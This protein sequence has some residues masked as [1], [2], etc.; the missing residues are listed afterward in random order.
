MYAVGLDVDTRAY[1]TAASMIIAV[2]TGIKVFSWLNITRAYSRIVREGSSLFDRFPR[3]NRKYLPENQ[4]C[5]T[6]V[7]FGYH[8]GSSVG[9]PNFTSIMAHI[10]TLPQYVFNVLVGILL[11]DG[12]L[13]HPVGVTSSPRFGFKL[14]IHAFGYFWYV[15]QMFMFAC[16]S[17]P[18]TDITV[19]PTGIHM[20]VY[21][22]T[23]SLACFHELYHVFYVNGVKVIPAN[24]YDLITIEGLAHIIMCDG[25][26]NS[27]ICLHLQAFSVQDNVRF[28]NVLMIKFGLQCA[29]HTERGKPVI[30]INTK[31]LKRIRAQL[32][33]HMVPS[34]HYK[35]YGR[36]N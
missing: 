27:G 31:S 4:N 7:P 3:S 25:A 21:F 23:R 33:P 30:Y 18:N 32:L 35:L 26:W 19:L 13:R 20:S 2:P 1:F 14:S 17:M 36:K 15:F 10:V 24:I 28:M 9:M 6:I 8:M 29:L 5:T 34:I 11:T 12:T 22:V 16:K